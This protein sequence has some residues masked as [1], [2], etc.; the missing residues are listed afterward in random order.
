MFDP[1]GKEKKFTINSQNPEKKI[2]N[3]QIHNKNT[4]HAKKEKREHQ[5][6]DHMRN[7]ERKTYQLVR[8]RC[9]QQ[10][11]RRMHGWVSSFCSMGSLMREIEK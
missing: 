1:F 6:D 3:Q 9:H 8:R 7:I 10:F 5:I 11:N 4:K 2:H